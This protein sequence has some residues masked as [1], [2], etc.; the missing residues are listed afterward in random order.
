MA[1]TG[2]TKSGRFLPPLRESFQRAAWVPSADLYRT[3]D[4]WLVKFDLAGVREQDLQLSFEGRK[5]TVSGCRRDLV[6]ERGVQHIQMEISYSRFER[7]VEFPEPVRG[8]K[9]EL[10]HDAGMLLVWIRSEGRR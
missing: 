3:A 1:D 2:E 6:A 9:C 8:A 10:Q 5:L 4:G 7:S